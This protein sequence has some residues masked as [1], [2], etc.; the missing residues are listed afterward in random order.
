MLMGT[1][2]GIEMGMRLTRIPHKEGGVM[3]ALRLLAPAG[4]I[5]AG[6]GLTQ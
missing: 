5:I 3:A 2:S 6:P 1:L 4:E